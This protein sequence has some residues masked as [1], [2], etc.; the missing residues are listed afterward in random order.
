MVE[1]IKK[2]FEINCKAIDD[3]AKD[4][5]KL[6]DFSADKYFENLFKNIELEMDFDKLN[7]KD[8]NL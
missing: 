6:F 4:L 7:I 3:Y 2:L 1:Q 5:N 8:I